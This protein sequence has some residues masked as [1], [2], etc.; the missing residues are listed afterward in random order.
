MRKFD[1][2]VLFFDFSL[3]NK[4]VVKKFKIGILWKTISL[5]GRKRRKNRGRPEIVLP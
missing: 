5:S 3:I 1:L 4:T 2:F